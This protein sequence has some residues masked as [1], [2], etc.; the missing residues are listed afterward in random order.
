[1]TS[2]DIHRIGWADS[3]GRSLRAAFDAEMDERYDDGPMTETQA[4][5]LD[6][7]FGVDERGIVCAFL[8]L[9]DGVPAGHGALFRRP[10]AGTFEVRK[11][12]VLQRVRGLGVGHRI[13]TA[14]EAHAAELGATRL[15]L[16]TGPRQPD[17][18]ALYESHGFER[19][20]PFPPYDTMPDAICFAKTLPPD[21]SD[22]SDTSAESGGVNGAV[23][24]RG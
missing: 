2:I 19:T 23:E 22:T 10:E 12:F 16:D 9:V 3:R 24:P 6:N 21:T 15:V 14:I 13:M 5:R 8:A 17:A 18:V 4:I 7:V 20:T 1:M 11:V